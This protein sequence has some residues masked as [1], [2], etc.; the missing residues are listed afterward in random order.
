MEIVKMFLWFLAIV[1]T[2]LMFY[3]YRYNLRESIN[4]AYYGK[5]KY[6]IIKALKYGEYRDFLKGF[7]ALMDFSKVNGAT[8]YR[9]LTNKEKEIVMLTAYRRGFMMKFLEDISSSYS[10]DMRVKNLYPDG[11]EEM[12]FFEVGPFMPVELTIRVHVVEE[13]VASLN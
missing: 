3:A 13:N 2:G 10:S 9:I 4:A 7:Y 5:K 1:Q 6:A 12:R 8:S 11:V